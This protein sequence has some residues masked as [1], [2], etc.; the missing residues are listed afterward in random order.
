MNQTHY[1]VAGLGVRVLDMANWIFGCSHRRTTFPRTIP[2]GASPDR[3]QTVQGEMYV[4]C[5]DCG[6]EITYDWAN[7]RVAKQKF[8]QTHMQPPSVRVSKK[9]LAPRGEPV[10]PQIVGVRLSHE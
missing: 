9:A 4:A 2:A 6:H 10:P 3:M 8:G 7:M 5:L 1:A